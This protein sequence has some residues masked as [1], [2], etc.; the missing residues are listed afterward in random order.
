MVSS[1]A[2]MRVAFV[3][4]VFWNTSV[5]FNADTFL[6]IATVLAVVKCR[7]NVAWIGKFWLENF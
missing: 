7:T 3:I 1:A 5:D 2:I 6:V 4:G